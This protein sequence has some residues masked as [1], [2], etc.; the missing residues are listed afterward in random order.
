MGPRPADAPWPMPGRPSPPLA[1]ANELLVVCVALNDATQGLIDREIIARLGAKGLLVN[2]ARGATVDEDALREALV[3]GALGGAALDVYAQE[4][5]PAAL[6]RG[7][8]NV[9]FSPHSGSST[10][11][12]L[13]AINEMVALNIERYFREGVRC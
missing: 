1:D 13:P 8:P 7:V 12:T 6:W 9:L 3:S 5:T 4:P 2:V 11:N 10:D